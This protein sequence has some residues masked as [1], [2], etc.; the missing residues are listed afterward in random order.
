MATFAERLDQALGSSGMSG[1]EALRRLQRDHDITISRSYLSQLRGGRRTTPSPEL[2]KGLAQVLGVSVGW[3]VGDDAPRE[4]APSLPAD[5]PSAH[6]VAADYMRLSPDS[7]R[8]LAHALRLMGRA[9]SGPVG[10]SGDDRPDTTSADLAQPVPTTSTHPFPSLEVDQARTRPQP[11]NIVGQ[12]LRNLRASAQLSTSDTAAILGAPTVA[13]D[14]IESG[15]QIVSPTDLRR[16]LTYYGVTNPAERQLMEEVARG[17][18]DREWWVTA[19]A[20][21]PL[22]LSVMLATES[23]ARIIR[24]YAVDGIPALLQTEA[25]AA[26]ARRAAHHPDPATDQIERAVRLIAQRQLGPVDQQTAKLWII[27]REAALLDMPGDQD[28]R[29]EQL[30]HLEYLAKQPHIAL[31][32]NRLHVGRYRPRGGSFMIYQGSGPTRAYVMGLIKD[33]LLTDPALVEEYVV[34]HYRLDMSAEP[35]ERTVSVL[36]EIR[37]QISAW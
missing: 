23:N 3:L 30:H 1:Q 31:R 37:R 22:W 9:E 11:G 15:R 36:A 13:I 8:A 33:E 17:Q 29:I 16:L 35:H 18:H 2:L 5:I 24:G 4:R 12:R 20:N 19:F 27:L 25:Y 7:Q 10:R 28:V 34:A 26:A 32:I 21:V 14:D 6:T